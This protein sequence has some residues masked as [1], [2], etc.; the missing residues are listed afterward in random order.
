VKS[1][2]NIPEGMTGK[3]FE[4]GTYAKLSTKGDIMQGVVGNKWSEIW[5][6]DLNRAFTADFEVYGAKAQNPSDA[7]IDFF[8]AVKQ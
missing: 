7:E 2:D 3:S 1:L 5:A 6:M 4:G 8:I